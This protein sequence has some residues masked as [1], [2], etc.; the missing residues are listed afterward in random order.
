MTLDTELRRTFDTLA[1]RLHAEIERQVRAAI[2][3]LPEQPEPAVGDEAHGAAAG[4]S[5]F[6]GVVQAIRL[7][8]ESRSLSDV[9][10]ALTTGAASEGGA[11]AVVLRRNGRWQPWRTIGCEPDVDADRLA[12]RASVP[13]VISGET[14]GVVYAEHGPTTGLEILARHASR[15]LE[16]MTAFRTARALARQHDPAQAADL[17][18]EDG[19]ARR[20]AKL[21]VSEIKLYHPNDVAAGCRERDLSAR[22]GGEIARARVLYEQRVPQHVRHRVDYFHEEL[23]RT[24]AGGDATLLKAEL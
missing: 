21:L 19:S 4:R 24:L 17:G 18:E 14:I 8:D 6:D 7:M 13:L 10:D 20:Y 15:C 3:E 1:E 22:L 16:A 9:L 23:V 11:A 5:D 12:D 2:A